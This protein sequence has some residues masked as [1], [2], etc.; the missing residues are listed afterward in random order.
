MS[1]VCAHVF[2]GSEIILGPQHLCERQGFWGA[3]LFLELTSFFR[4]DEYIPVH[5]SSTKQQQKYTC[6]YIL[7]CPDLAQATLKS[8]HLK[9]ICNRPL[10]GSGLG[11]WLLEAG[12]NSDSVTMLRASS[13]A[14]AL[15]PETNESTACL[16][17]QLI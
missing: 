9:L 3:S 7:L 2:P 12:F 10:D 11:I 6:A 8:C 17:Q 16:L 13:P 5:T 14:D 4:P 1:F 15:L